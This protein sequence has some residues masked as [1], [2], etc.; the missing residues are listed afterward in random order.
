LAL[1]S[2][3]WYA[4]TEAGVL[5]S[6]NEGKSW[7]G[8]AV[9]GEKGFLS[10]SAQGENV[11]AST[12]RDVW[13]SRDEAEHWSRQPVPGWVTRIYSVSIAA[14]GAVW[15]GSR[16]GALRWT[17][18]AGEWEHVLN[19]LPPREVFA[20]RDREGVMVAAVAGSKTMYVSRNQGQS[21]QAEPASSF[22]VTGAAVQGSTLYVTTRHHGVLVREM[23][24]ASAVGSH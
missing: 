6:E 9:D 5:V 23:H 21:W 19:G 4:A 1:G 8:G 10:V 13:Y 7:K 12:M 22:E 3:H 18:G 16:E 17:P 15:I 20:I 14:D 24:A 2:K 11:A